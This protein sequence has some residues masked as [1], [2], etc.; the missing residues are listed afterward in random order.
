MG[1]N[2]R[3]V[4][5]AQR[6]K[7]KTELDARLASLTERGLDDKQKGKD[8][9]VR[10]LKADIRALNMRLATI[11]ALEKKKQDLAERKAAKAAAPKVKKKGKKAEAPPPETKGKGKKKQKK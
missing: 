6:E 2:E 1:S 9:V 11:D 8:P 4:Q 7:T 5:L 10:H 3:D